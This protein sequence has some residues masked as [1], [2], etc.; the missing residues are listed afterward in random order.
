[1]QPW[2]RSRWQRLTIINNTTGNPLTFVVTNTGDSGPGTLRDAITA[3]NADPN[4]GVD[5][6]VFEI[7]ASTAGNQNIP[8]S[9]FDPITQIWTI[10]LAERA[11]GDHAFG[12][13]RRIHG[14]QYCGAVPVPGSGQLGR[15]GSDRRRTA[16][17]RNVQPFHAR[18]ASRRHDAADSILGD[19]QN[20]SSKRST[21]FWEPTAF[22]SCRRRPTHLPSRF[23]E[24][25][26]MKRSPT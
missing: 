24:Q 10:S 19:S 6:I 12:H 23:R 7:P 3:A 22:R 14:G 20:R 25:T 2:A 15:A 26:R 5:N 13:D 18:A 4:P 8:V 17:R 9:G 16:H 1:M 21:R 11:A